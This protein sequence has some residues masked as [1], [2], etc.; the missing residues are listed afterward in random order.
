[1]NKQLTGFKT[2]MWSVVLRNFSVASEKMHRFGL[3]SRFKAMALSLEA[4]AADTIGPKPLGE[5]LSEI[6][7]SLKND[8]ADRIPLAKLTAA[9]TG[10]RGPLRALTWGAKVAAIQSSVIARFL[11]SPD[12]FLEGGKQIYVCEACGFI[13]VGNRALDI[14]PVCKAPASRFSAFK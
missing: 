5:V 13:F 10:H 7:T 2:N 8:T 3:A 6:L 4:I 9:D 14:C 1:M 12:T 11:K